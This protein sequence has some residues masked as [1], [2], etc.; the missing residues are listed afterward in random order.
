MTFDTQPRPK[1]AALAAACLLT[2]ALP[3]SAVIAKEKVK[4][5]AVET[6][7]PATPAAVPP[8]FSV[9]IPTIDAIGSN[10][11]EPTLRAIFSGDLIDNA[12]A[13]A[14]LTADSITIPAI[15][16]SFTGEVDGK[17]ESGQFS[18]NNLVLDQVRDGVAT[19]FSLGGVKLTSD[20]D[21]SGSFGAVSA[22]NFDIGGILGV[23]GL[24]KT[25]PQTEL[26]TLYSDFKAEGGSMQAEDV[27]CHIGAMET[28]EFKGRPLKYSFAELMT[29]AQALDAEEDEPSPEIIG[30][31]LHMY[32]DI[33][34]AFE[35]SPLTFGGFDCTG[36]D[37]TGEPV[38]FSIA[39]MT[40][41]GIAP[42]LY[43]AI[44]MDGFR[45]KIEDG[46][47]GI[48][49]I[50][51][52]AMDLSGPIAAVQAA[53]AAIDA[54]WL[55]ANARALIPAFAG[56]S[57]SD[58]VMDIPNPDAKDERIKANVG[59]FDL[60]LADYLHG[61]PTNFST[62]GNKIVFKLPDHSSDE[63]IQQLIDLG[64]GSLDFGFAV[65]A[66]WDEATNA[67]NIEDV[68]IDGVDL[69]R[70]GL[71]GTIG[72]A[73]EA[74]F[75]ID[76]DM[77]LAAAMGVV[78]KNLKVDVTDAGLSDIILARV[79]ADQGSDATTMRPIFGGLAEGTILGMLAGAAEA[80]KVGKAVN[81]FIA[82]DAKA[83]TIEMTA[84]DP[85]GLGLADF[86]AAED[87]PTLLIGKTN[88]TATAK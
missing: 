64:I 13:L 12:E 35:S 42:G 1:F 41:D 53:P 33:F 19:S 38:D 55:E 49:N 31:A 2:V 46:E 85:A 4:T 9:E 51:V 56:F 16:V 6:T 7:A 72:N 77:A 11:D 3:S 52:K 69:A 87:D 81:A 17:S 54:A 32:A 59:A 75:G 21:V 8:K 61:I 23:Y 86:I 37:D 74:L 62:T 45:I 88:I 36:T 71:S 25:A 73:T 5:P 40:M 60:S 82:G 28:A 58:F 47:M 63:Q 39:S 76:P 15:T 65:K 80:Q 20:A 18:L 44:S 70:V 79:A 57:I 68:S 10:L 34:T 30:M 43:P 24:I 84:K 67:I 22:A 48:G 27:S 29:M 50:S 83:L 78:I 14:S 26:T 66:A